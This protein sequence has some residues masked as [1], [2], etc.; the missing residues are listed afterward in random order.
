MAEIRAAAQMRVNDFLRKHGEL[1]DRIAL[2]VTLVLDPLLNY[3]SDIDEAIFL[4]LQNDLETL[5]E[6]TEKEE[7][8][9]YVHASI[10]CV[11]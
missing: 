10:F 5:K 4:S 8:R 7:V 2:T 3:E 11:H 6:R 1:A 9:I